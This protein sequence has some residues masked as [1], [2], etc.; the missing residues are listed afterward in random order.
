MYKIRYKYLTATQ[1]DCVIIAVVDVL[2]SGRRCVSGRR[3]SGLR[4]RYRL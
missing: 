2:S 3:G 1:E 4:W